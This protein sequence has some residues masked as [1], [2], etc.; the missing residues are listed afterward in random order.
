MV[1]EQ[2]QVLITWSDW[3]RAEQTAARLP[4]VLDGSPSLREWWFIRKRP[5][6]RL[7]YSGDPGAG[8]LLDTE[9][10][11]LQA[12]GLVSGWVHS[13]YEPETFA[14]G[15]RASM[16]LAHRLFQADSRYTLAYLDRAS[17]DPER[18]PGRR[19]LS[20]LLG[21]AL[22][23]GAGLDWFEQADVWARVAELRPSTEPFTPDDRLRVQVHSLMRTDPGR[24][25]AAD[26]LRALVPW[27]DAF[28]TTGRSLADLSNRGLLTRGIRSVLAHHLIFAFNR[29][30]LPYRDQ[31]IL[32]TTAREVVMTDT[33]HTTT[34]SVDADRL[35][36]ELVDRLRQSGSIRTDAVADAFRSVPRHS[37]VPNASLEE[38][39]ANAPVHIKHDENGV[40]ISCGSQPGVVAMMLE[41]AALEPGMRV[42]E[43]GAGTGFNAALLGHLVGP[44]GSVTTIDVDTDLADGARARLKENGVT[45]VRVLLGDGSLGHPEGAPFDRIIATVGSHD[46]PR[47]WVDQLAPGGRLIAPVR[48]A[49]DVSRSIVFEA[50]DDQWAS[51]DSRLCTFMPLRGGGIGDDPRT[52]LA[53]DED[54][55]VL[56]QA[57][58]D[59]AIERAQVHEVLAEPSRTVWS[60]VTFGKGQPLDP[61]WLWLATHLPN[62]LS[63][64]AATRVA[65]D[66]RLV[67]PGL[68]WG[69]MAGVPVVE[70]GLAYLTLR[71]LEDQPDRHELG[72]IGHAEAGYVLAEQMAAHVAAWAPHRE[73]PLNFT[74]R[75]GS[76]PAGE[77]A[78][79]RV[80]A[81][82]R[83][84]L[85]VTWGEPA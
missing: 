41:Q 37:F 56:L 4:P 39:Y 70:R 48:I 34:S 21:S 22:L 5:H 77:S 75:Y 15:G 3:E 13:A 12:Q 81:R 64:M 79:R 9:L 16:A 7:R 83:S 11:R 60:G 55:S 84:S 51:T 74:L 69:D 46:V 8:D 76:V 31:H 53:L 65:V 29:W 18:E 28:T 62:R 57:N 33:T 36:G 66:S 35:R 14:F 38:A 61:M 47:A 10:E 80:M 32:T 26:L 25:G 63:R 44:N 68:P 59:Q 27:A 85:V 1:E 17:T 58:Q 52:V 73:E 71:P 82:E 49:G 6:W 42:L 78:T 43:V 30:G 2:G 72:V 19:E 24:T 20:L 67:S 50:D 40:S 45:N 54:A 23:R